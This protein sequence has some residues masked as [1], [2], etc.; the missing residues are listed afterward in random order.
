M[1]ALRPFGNDFRSMVPFQEDKGGNDLQLQRQV[2]GYEKTFLNWL[3]A[4]HN[5]LRKDQINVEEVQSLTELLMQM[6][7]EEQDDYL[8]ALLRPE[9]MK[10]CKIPSTIPQASSAFQLHNSI[11]VNTNA[12]G[13]A[14]IVFNPFFLSSNTVTPNLSTL[15]VNNNAALTG[16]A[17]SNFFV[18]T[19]IDQTIPNVYSQYRLVSASVVVKYIG[20]L[21]IV[22][23]VIGGA[24]AF[25]TN[26]AATDATAAVPLAALQKYGNFNLAQDSYYFQEH[27][28][29]N[30][31]RELYFPLDTTFEAF[32]E[33]GGTSN[34]PKSGFAFLLY[35]QN[36]VYQAGVSNYK[37]DVYCNYECYANAEFLNYIP[38]TPP[39]MASPTAKAHAL[40]TV[41]ANAI[42]DAEAGRTQLRAASEPSFWDKLKKGLGT[43]I[44]SVTQIAS[45]LIPGSKI[46]GPVLQAVGSLFGQQQQQR[47]TPGFIPA[48]M[49]GRMMLDG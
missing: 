1:N 26:V 22:K 29:L 34:D 40:Q 7:A 35:L 43:I 10:G 3:V 39:A 9:L 31:M 33:L 38:V 2:E 46:V 45:G 21:D 37:I 17:P 30:G 49:T 8:H 15:Y 14:A 13:H 44:P 20:Q 32:R 11:T 19:S 48:N 6:R 36:G 47:Q 23:G 25:D 27:M 24:I 16:A 28:T 18:P 42:S 12:S 5:A 4:M 41:Q